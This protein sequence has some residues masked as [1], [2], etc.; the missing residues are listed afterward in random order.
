MRRD[1]KTLCLSHYNYKPALPVKVK[2]PIVP[3]QF[4]VPVERQLSA[5]SAV[6]VALP[7]KPKFAPPPDLVKN[8]REFVWAMFG[9]EPKRGRP[10]SQFKSAMV[11]IAPIWMPRDATVIATML[12]YSQSFTEFALNRAAEFKICYEEDGH[13]YYQGEWCHVFVEPDICGHP[14]F[15]LFVS[16]TLDTMVVEGALGRGVEVDGDHKG[17][18]WYKKTGIFDKLCKTDSTALRPAI[19]ALVSSSS[20]V[21]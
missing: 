7:V 5:A 19:S 11:M 15:E 16:F 6:S 4:V 2:E 8:M 17:E 14:L 13:L 1:G 10:D 12:G 3:F 18:F 9:E 20:E 21:S